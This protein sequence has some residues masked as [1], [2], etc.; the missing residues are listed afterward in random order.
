[1]LDQMPTVFIML[2]N[3]KN[4]FIEVM[5]RQSKGHD[6]N[7]SLVIPEMGALAK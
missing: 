1:M 5:I 3:M 7:M 4:H 6:S 2:A